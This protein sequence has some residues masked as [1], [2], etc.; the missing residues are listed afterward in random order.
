MLLFLCSFAT[1]QDL[2][3]IKED[4]QQGNLV[5]AKQTI[6]EF[7]I[8]NP[9]DAAGWL[10]K[11]RIYNAISNDAGLKDLTLDSRMTAFKSVKKATELNKAL[12]KE[13]LAKEEFKLLYDIYKG[14]TSDGIAFFNAGTE[15]KNKEDYA[16]AITNF[17]KAGQVNSFLFDNGWGGDYPDLNNLYYSCLSAIYA[18]KKFEAY[19]DAVKITDRQVAFI[20]P[21]KNFQPIYQWLAFYMK[22]GNEKEFEKITN[23]AIKVFPNAPYFYLN[24]IDWLR[25][26]KRYAEMFDW[27]AKLMTAFKKESKYELSY[28]ND[29]FR[30]TYNE[31]DSL[32]KW[33]GCHSI[34]YGLEQFIEKNPGNAA[35]RLLLAKYYINKAAD[36]KKVNAA[37]STVKKILAQSNVQL[38]F[39]VDKA[40][41]KQNTIVV[42]ALKLLVSNYKS[43][44]ELQK[45]A[46]Y[47]LMLQSD[48]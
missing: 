9:D 45:V 48:K 23:T 42:E 41:V 7:T 40:E 6:D 10:L 36:A 38:K 4:W 14:Y 18:G 21:D 15:K 32:K 20:A 8:A 29:L 46:K 30:V 11:G 27:Y 16:A 44:G 24:Y 43:Q 26:K 2:N 35:A 25:D 22:D 39:I 3:A 47:Q 31:P 28:Y 34:E 5:T 19:N 37:K 12:V 13:E 17:K 33:N 1:A